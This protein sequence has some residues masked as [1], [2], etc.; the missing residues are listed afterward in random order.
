MIIQTNRLI[1]RELNT[2]DALNFYRLNSDPEVLKHTG[3]R[4][5]NCERAAFDFLKSY[6]ANNYEKYNCGR[7]AVLL[8]NT[9]EWLGWCGLKYSPEKNETDLGYRFFREYWG[10]GYATEA[11]MA[12]ID[13]GFNKLN[14]NKIVGRAMKENIA[15]II[16]L[17]KI[18]MQFEKEFLMDG[19][20]PAV[21]YSIFK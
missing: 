15:S 20:Y 9:N 12:S 10:N 13:Y 18:G 7:W 17:K 11:A 21:Q 4:P 14:L 5:F 3:D 16:V 8:L 2:N 6:P 1:L 19:I